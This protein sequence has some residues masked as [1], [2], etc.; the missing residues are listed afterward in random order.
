MIWEQEVKCI[1][2]LCQTEEKEK[3]GVI[4]SI[5]SVQCI[6]LHCVESSTNSNKI[7]KLIYKS[8]T[9]HLSDIILML[10]GGLLSILATGKR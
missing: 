4:K 3:V 6:Q 5:N 2:M 7:A 10:L 9:P 1:V 8:H